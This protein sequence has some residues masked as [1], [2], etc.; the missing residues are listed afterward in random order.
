MELRRIKSADGSAAV[1][2]MELVRVRSSSLFEGEWKDGRPWRGSGHFLSKD[3]ATSFEGFFRKGAPF[4]GVGTWVDS[5]GRKFTGKIEDAWPVSGEGAILCLGNVY[6]GA[7]EGGVGV[8]TIVPLDAVAA[9]A[10]K[11]AREWRGEFSAADASVDPE[12]RP[13]R[14]S[15]VFISHEGLC[16]TGEWSGG[17]VVRGKGS[18]R[19]SSSGF[20]LEGEFTKAACGK[21]KI[22]T[23]SGH[24]RDLTF[25]G[26]W[27][28]TLPYNG[29]G[30]IAVDGT[31]FKGE[32]KEGKRYHHGKKHELVDDVGAAL[33]R[34]LD[35][36]ADAKTKSLCALR[37]KSLRALPAMADIKRSL[38]ADSLDGADT[39]RAAQRAA[40]RDRRLEKERVKAAL[41]S[42]AGGR[43][44]V[45]PA[46]I[47]SLPA[48]EVTSSASPSAAVKP[49]DLYKPSM[50]EPTK[51]EKRS[52]A[53]KSAGVG[54]S[55]AVASDDLY[56]VMKKEDKLKGELER[57][58][59][60]SNL[61]SGSIRRRE[62]KQARAPK[63]EK[64]LTPLEKALQQLAESAPTRGPS[65][66]DGD[67]KTKRKPQQAQARAA[68]DT[69]SKDSAAAAKA[70]V[71]AIEGWKKNLAAAKDK[72]K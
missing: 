27:R 43:E 53:L 6:D 37:S 67:D 3:G 57:S 61:V 39:I 21:G 44:A 68:T 45:S 46:A 40:R 26:E 71:A 24:K 52:V 59:M 60:V 5:A 25:E 36:Q 9:G 18:W 69:S 72:R 55:A 34:H 1:R 65:K 50:E 29:K 54:S 14:G 20:L 4:Q 23:L 56:P 31:T 42:T 35:K 58:K 70:G 22:V 62:E 7:W 12:Q 16:C 13:V 63:P 64:Q 11:E 38:S 49:L 47:K 10:M 8:G 17:E 51:D 19:S 15:G 66:T 48:L 28:D 30:E 32:W 33:R 41:P 2:A